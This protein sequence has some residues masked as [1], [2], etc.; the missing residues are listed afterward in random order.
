MTGLPTAH[1]ALVYATDAGQHVALFWDL[2]RQRCEQ[3]AAHNAEA[4]PR[5]L[6][7]EADLVCDGHDHPGR[8]DRPDKIPPQVVD[9]RAGHGPGNGDFKADSK[10]GAWR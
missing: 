2:M 4:V 8:C 10:I 5:V 7:F 9:P 3:A 1:D 6:S